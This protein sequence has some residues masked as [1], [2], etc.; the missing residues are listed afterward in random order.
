ME[1]VLSYAQ[2]YS[3]A[4]ERMRILNPIPEDAFGLFADLAKLDQSSHILDIGSG[5]GY[6]ALALTNH[7]GCVSTQVD[8]SD[9]WNRRARTLFE[10]HELLEKTTIIGAD[11][12]EFTIEKERYDMIICLGNSPI[13]GGYAQAVE[14]FMP[15]LKEQGTILIG[16]ATI[17]EDIP[18]DYQSYL[19]QL[20]WILP[21]EEE[22]I[23]AIEE[24]NLELLYARR[25]SVEEWDQYMGM[26][27]TTVNDY[28]RDHPQDDI[29][30]ELVDWL[31]DEQESYLR[32][33]RHFVDWTVYLLRK[34]L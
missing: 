1:S 7:A 15:G 8:I 10:Q 6:T 11:A 21:N 14:A 22:L 32:F 3:I 19:E 30:G 28:I 29:T 16:E 9:E 26:Q 25:S 31:R 27:W 24:Q 5:K 33:Q 2:Y 23:L 12:S 13:Y 20:E 17:R 34:P 18:A 4:Y